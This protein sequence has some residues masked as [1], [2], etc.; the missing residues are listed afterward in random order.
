MDTIHFETLGDAGFRCSIKL[1]STTIK[2]CPCTAS[3]AYSKLS[4]FPAYPSE[5]PMLIERGLQEIPALRA[6]LETAVG[7][8]HSVFCLS[9]RGQKD[10]LYDERNRELAY[11]TQKDHQESGPF[12]QRR[13]RRETT[14]SSVEKYNQRLDDERSG[15]EVDDESVCDPFRGPIYAAIIINNLPHTQNSGYALLCQNQGQTLALCNTPK[16][17]KLGNLGFLSLAITSCFLT[18]GPVSAGQCNKTIMFT[19]GG[20]ESSRQHPA[21]SYPN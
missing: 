10:Y 14:L 13:C 3:F 6:D 19:S 18:C 5:V 2:F 4:E 16:S 20:M 21:V 17:K 9:C 12:P 15:M 8:S 7:A 11:A 1:F